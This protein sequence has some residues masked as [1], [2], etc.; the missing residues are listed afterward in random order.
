M[1]QRNAFGLACLLAAGTLIGSARA[2]ETPE[3]WSK[4]LTFGV[5]AT[6][7][8]FDN[9]AGGGEDAIAWQAQ[10]DGKALRTYSS[11][12]WEVTGKVAYGETKLGDSGFRKSTDELKLGTVFT[13]NRNAWINPYASGT[14]ATQ[15]AEGFDYTLTPK[16][17]TSGFFN[18][19][20]ITEAFGVGH[21]YQSGLKLKLGLAAKQTLSEKLTVGGVD[22][23]WADDPETAKVE[24]LRS[25]FGAEFVAEYEH[26]FNESVTFKS[27]LTTFWAAGP[28]DETDADWDSSLTASITD[29]IKVSFNLRI[30]RDADISRTRQ[31]K[32]NLAIGLIYTLI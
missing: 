30:L 23:S 14:F 4:S 8:S 21:D 16:V 20:Y 15:L 27:K 6:Q 28:F 24:T 31:L 26:A 11:S 25:E 29:A 5:N 17:K 18:P 3:G 7:A 19:A 9:W 13:W 2:E 22:F 1:T 32:Q 12:S 10:F